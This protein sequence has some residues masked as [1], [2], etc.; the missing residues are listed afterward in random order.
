MM[1]SLKDFTSRKPISQSGLKRYCVIVVCD[2]KDKTNDTGQ[3]LSWMTLWKS[4]V[5]D[6]G[7]INE[8]S[9]RFPNWEGVSSLVLEIS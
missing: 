7:Q 9:I 8:K 6:S 2:Q 5:V 4:A 1:D 3:F